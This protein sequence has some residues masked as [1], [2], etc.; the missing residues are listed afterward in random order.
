MGCLT[1]GGDSGM[2]A[3]FCRVVALTVLDRS[4]YAGQ[5]LEP[6]KQAPV[7]GQN[8]RPVIVLLQAVAENRAEAF[9]QK[10]SAKRR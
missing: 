4:V 5:A 10:R 1:L 3:R 2:R 7:E 9:A 6:G 8:E